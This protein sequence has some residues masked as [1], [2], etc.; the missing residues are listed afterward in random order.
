LLA[1]LSGVFSHLDPEERKTSLEP[2]PVPQCHTPGQALAKT[3]LYGGS[4]GIV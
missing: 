4:N 3:L 2:E 1:D